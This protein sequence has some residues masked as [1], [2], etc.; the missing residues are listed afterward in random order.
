MIG[1]RRRRSTAAVLAGAHVVRVHAVERDAA[2]GARRRRDSAVSSRR[3]MNWLT[4]LLQAPDI[5]WADA[6]DIAIVSFL[7]YELLLL[8]RGTRAVQMAVERRFLLL[9]CS[10]CR[11]G[12]SSRRS[13]G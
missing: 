5:G 4:A 13:T 1:P 11:S 9:L 7:S 12:C 10:S 6:L 8:I 2:G 3:L